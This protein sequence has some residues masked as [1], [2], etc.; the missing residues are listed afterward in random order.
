LGLWNYEL[1]ACLITKVGVE[2]NMPRKERCPKCGSG[3]ITAKASSKKC[4]V[5]GYAWSGRVRTS[6][7]KK[8]KVRF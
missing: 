2:K 1:Q 6:H 7:V 5:C 8:D 4:K 3:K